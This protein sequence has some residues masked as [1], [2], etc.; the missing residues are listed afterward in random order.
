MSLSPKNGPDKTVHKSMIILFHKI[1]NLLL[2]KEAAPQQRY[3]AAYEGAVLAGFLG[4]RSAIACPPKEGKGKC[5]AV[6]GMSYHA[7]YRR[8]AIRDIV[9]DEIVEYEDV[10]ISRVICSQC[11]TTHALLLWFVPPYSRHTLRFI[12]TVLQEHYQKT[13]AV[14]ALCAKYDITHPTLYA[15]DARYHGQCDGLRA[16]FDP[17]LLP[18]APL[19]FEQWENGTEA[20]GQPQSARPA[21]PMPAMAP[22]TDKDDY[23]A[24]SGTP[25]HGPEANGAQAPMPAA[26]E[27]AVFIAIKA[28]VEQDN[29]A[30]FE[31]FYAA[32]RTAFFQARQIRGCA[33][34]AGERQ[35]AP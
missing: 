26:F 28:A 10:E 5:G 30:L 12:F 27:E 25:A 14:E 3:K 2:K 35:R 33:G 22:G 24:T 23:S 19:E 29:T 6:G 18:D 21:P 11:Q 20:A 31:G 34:R 4:G 7:K 17:P 16:L 13:L 9:D 15:W 8:A 32:R 1:I